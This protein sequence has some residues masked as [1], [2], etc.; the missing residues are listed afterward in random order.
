M[1]DVST[2]LGTIALGI[3]P[4][5][6]LRG[7]IPFAYLRGSPLWEAALLGGAANLLVSPLAYIFLATI[8]KLLHGRWGFYT[9]LFDATVER[10]RRKLAP[11]VNTYGFLGILLFVGVP[12]P[13]TGAWT[14]TLGAWILGLDPKHSIAAVSGGVV[15]ACAIVTTVLALGHGA[16]SLFVKIM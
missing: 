11:K 13:V 10:A 9:R 3:L 12:L 5:S 6:E 4:I 1:M 14:G 16:A 15:M 2:V 8:H 7:A